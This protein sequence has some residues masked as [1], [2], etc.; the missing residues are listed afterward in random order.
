MSSAVPVVH[1]VAGDDR[2][3]IE[4]VAW[5]WRIL[6]MAGYADLTLGHVSVRGSDGRTIYIKRKGVALG[7]VTPGDVVAVDLDADLRQRPA[8][9]HLETV[10]HT[11]VLQAPAGRPQ[12]RARSPALRDGVRRDRC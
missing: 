7:E 5:A 8:G 10:L 4:D 12:R 1:R 6:A 3:S 11:E 2:A 9:M